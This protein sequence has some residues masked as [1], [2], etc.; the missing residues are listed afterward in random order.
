MSLLKALRK[1]LHSLT[2]C[3]LP[4]EQLEI[5]RQAYWDLIEHV[6]ENPFYAVAYAA[7]EGVR[8]PYEVQLRAVE[9]AA[10]VGP[11]RLAE[12]P[13]LAE[14]VF[15]KAGALF[16]NVRG[17]VLRRGAK[18]YLEICG[19][20]ERECV[21]DPEKRLALADC[22]FPPKR[23]PKGDYHGGKKSRDLLLL[24]L[25]DEN[26]VPVDRHVDYWACQVAGLYCPRKY[27]RGRTLPPKEYRAI[28]EAIREAA[29][30]CNVTPAELMVSVWVYGVCNRE[31]GAKP[32]FPM[33]DEIY[34]Y[35]RK[36][37]TTLE[38]HYER[39][40]EWVPEE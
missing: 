36:G 25:G 6:R 30:A 10:E 12:E 9:L 40:E 27:E 18:C 2:S 4:E 7:A 21:E 20:D 39:P 38:E 17:E 14:R 3:P 37:Q 26:A 22:M 35:C 33:V 29:E 24:A 5:G 8:A 28:Q 31:V 19:K 11:E 34:V 32:A 15:E 23:R 13:G 1:F 16:G